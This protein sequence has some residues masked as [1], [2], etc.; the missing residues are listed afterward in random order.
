MFSLRKEP[1][2]LLCEKFLCL[3]L[4]GVSLSQQHLSV[5]GL[6][7]C[8]C[9]DMWLQSPF[10]S[11]DYGLQQSIGSTPRKPPHFLF[12]PQLLSLCWEH[13]QAAK[14]TAV[15]T[16][17]DQTGN[18]SIS[19]LP[20]RGSRAHTSV[21]AAHRVGIPHPPGRE[22]GEAQPTSLLLFLSLQGT[23]PTHLV[24]ALALEVLAV[25]GAKPKCF[26]TLPCTGFSCCPLSLVSSLVVSEPFPSPVC[27]HVPPLLHR[28]DDTRKLN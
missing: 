19:W 17:R 18:P 25:T 4:A 22:E 7:V 26:L 5:P 12:L 16:R 20:A 3:C 8:S 13:L 14:T 10:P 6:L 21:G 24:M 23:I 11:G 27:V 28:T 15:R 1:G 9:W 2:D